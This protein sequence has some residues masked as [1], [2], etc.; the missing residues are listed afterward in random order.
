[1]RNPESS[2]ETRSVTPS[3]QGDGGRPK[4]YIPPVGP[5]S[6]SV[7]PVGDWRDL[8][9]GILPEPPKH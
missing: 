2:P 1:M 8:P 9:P 3:V 5:G 4:E 6:K 7:P